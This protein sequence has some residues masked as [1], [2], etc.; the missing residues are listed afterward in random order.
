MAGFIIPCD[1]STQYINT[2]ETRDAFD[3]VTC[4][5]PTCFRSFFEQPNTL[6]TVAKMLRTQSR[7]NEGLY[8]TLHPSTSIVELLHY[9]RGKPMI[10][11]RMGHFYLFK[12]HCPAFMQPIRTS[13]HTEATISTFDLLLPMSARQRTCFLPRASSE[14]R[15]MGQAFLQL[16]QARNGPSRSVLYGSSWCIVH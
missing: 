11:S 10:K 13:L 5:D 4:C 2:R 6:L 15:G 16:D 9:R 8:R 14:H 3:R 12:I 1:N 7:S